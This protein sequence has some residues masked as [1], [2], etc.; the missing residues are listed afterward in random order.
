[1]LLGKTS[2]NKFSNFLRMNRYSR[3]RSRSRERRRSRSRSR[4]KSRDRDRRFL[5]SDRRRNVTDSRKYDDRKDFDEK[6]TDDRK[7]EF[8][9]DHDDSTRD[10]GNRR[11]KGNDFD[12]RD[13]EVR[14]RVSK[15]KINEN[16]DDRLNGAT[17]VGGKKGSNNHANSLDNIKTD[18]KKEE[19]EDTITS[20]QLEKFVEGV[21]DDVD[22]EEEAR[23][24][25]EERRRRRQEI[26]EKFQGNHSN[27]NSEDKSVSCTST[28]AVSNGS[29]QGMISAAAV[30][31][32]HANN[33]ADELEAE[34]NAV[35]EEAKHDATGFDIF[36]CSPAGNELNNDRGGAQKRALRAALIDGEDP[37][38]QSNWDDSEGYY[39]PCIGELIAGRFRTTAVIGKGV[40]STVLKCVD[41][42]KS[43][44][45]DADADV[46]AI[47][48]IRN[49]D[50]MRKAAEKELSLLTAIARADPENKKH[51]VRLL[52]HTEY[53]NHV[54]MV[55]EPLHM[56]LRETLKKFGKNVGINI[57]AV[58]LYARQLF[59]ALKHISDLDIVHADL[60]PGT[61]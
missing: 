23:R 36:S 58:R 17:V 19:D 30:L 43:T 27:T 21:I 60:K 49:N 31:L 20:E 33:G 55:F 46:V 51:C 16:Q 50:T 41:V 56:N 6:R 12:R 54:A 48:M 3:D 1:M 37:H 34:R 22:E 61:R 24:I 25:A 29:Q 59:V 39:K 13:E 18:R 26:L 35:E 32:P 42:S 7:R 10:D 8:R 4:E 28:A 38:L 40:F 2:S 45:D 11:R 5:D 57:S 52:M 14:D 9:R 15:R 53:R 44:D 47:K